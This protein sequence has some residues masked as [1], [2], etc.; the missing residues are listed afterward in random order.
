[1][2]PIWALHLSEPGILIASEFD[3]TEALIAMTD[4]AF[5]IDDP[6]D[7]FEIEAVDETMHSDWLN[8]K[9]EF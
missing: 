3:G 6:H 2:S 5:E 1:M 8:P 4:N 9:E 7:Y